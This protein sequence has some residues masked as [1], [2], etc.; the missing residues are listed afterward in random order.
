MPPYQAQGAWRRKSRVLTVLKLVL[1]LP[2]NFSPWPRKVTCNV[3][4]S[5]RRTGLDGHKMSYTALIPPD[6]PGFAPDNPVTAT[7]VGSNRA[8]LWLYSLLGSLGPLASRLLLNEVKKVALKEGV[9]VARLGAR[10]LQ[11][12]VSKA[13][14]KMGGS[15]GRKVR[16]VLLDRKRYRRRGRTKRRPRYGKR[17]MKKKS[18]RRPRPRE[19]LGARRGMITRTLGKRWY[20]WTLPHPNQKTRWYTPYQPR[21]V[22]LPRGHSV[23]R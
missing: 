7:L 19:G 21:N 15:T 3:T 2:T 18:K 11:Q 4:N 1:V 13:S 20:R 23:I 6:Y 16:A 10:K 22:K 17:W 9:N 8:S 5:V 12:I 14:K